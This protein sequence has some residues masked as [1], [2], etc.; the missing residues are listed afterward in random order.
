MPTLQQYIAELREFISIPSVSAGPLMKGS[1]RQCAVWLATQLKNAG[2]KRVKVFETRLHPIVYADYLVDASLPTIL[3]YGHY[4]VQPA[5]PLTDWLSEP[6]NPII[7]GNYIVGRGA[8]DDKS[9]LLV[10]VKAI[11][12]LILKNGAPP[13]NIKCLFE[14]EEEIGSPNLKA[15]ITANKQLLACD[16]AVI[17]DTNMAAANQPAVTYSLRG[18]L[19]LELTLH[20]QEKE[21]HSGKYGGTVYN[22]I[23][24]LSEIIS[25][26]HQQD[27][28]VAIPGFYD[29]IKQPGKAEKAYMSAYGPSNK[30]LMA[31]AGTACQWG[32]AG[33]TAYERATIR[34]S[35]SITSV[36]AGYQGEGAKNSIP[37]A[38]TAKIN[39]R[40][41]PGQQP[42]RLEFLT[43]AFI[44]EVTPPGFRVSIK[45]SSPAMPVVLPTGNC[46]LK[47][48]ALAYETAFGVKPIFLRSGGTIPVV[49]MF[50]EILGAPTVLMGFALPSDNMHG[51]NEQFY[52]PNFIKGIQTSI[53]FMNNVSSLTKYKQTK[54]LSR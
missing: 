26:F 9:Q 39:I 37:N 41:V 21:L 42:A 20:G 54:H 10:H 25:Q 46:F 34:P 35:L 50:K 7:K 43:R 8:S 49:N 22:P 4:D 6:F 27:N 29:G 19:N 36:S 28:R 18:S 1:V 3:F 31:A 47:A 13:V 51:P 48:A 12:E 38:A 17:S 11:E 14:G 2:L 16:A 52:L 45:A 44:S 5:E 15:F 40:L 32:E 33:H 23:Q 53:H 24:A 30:A